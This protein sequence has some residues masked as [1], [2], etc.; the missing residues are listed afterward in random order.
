MISL[1]HNAIIHPI[2]GVLWWVGATSLADW[3]HEVTIPDLKP[4]SGG[5]G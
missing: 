4:S 3:L 5:E 2:C 1:F